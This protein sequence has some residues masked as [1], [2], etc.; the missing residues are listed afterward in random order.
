MAPT[1]LVLA[2]IALL[3]TVFAS[4]IGYSQFSKRSYKPHFPVCPYDFVPFVYV[5]CYQDPNAK[6]LR[7]NPRINGPD[8]TVE[9]CTSACKN[10]GF[11]YAGLEYYG[12]CKC[13]STIAGNPFVDTGNAKE[14][15]IFPCNGNPLQVCGGNA[16]ISIY[17]DPTFPI[18][19]VDELATAGADYE[20]IGCFSEVDGRTL[21]DDQLDINGPDM[22]IEKCL[23]QCG[24]QGYAYAG[25]EYG[26]ECWCAGKIA[27]DALPIDDATRCNLPCKGNKDE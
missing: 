5:G 27:P 19:T 2:A 1:K 6:T 9:K 26:Q 14:G 10:N 18:K 21:T 4:G 11:R 22:T 3:D 24:K 15:C 8:M 13:G 20:A 7:F 12:Q 17:I 16:M 23:E 25:L